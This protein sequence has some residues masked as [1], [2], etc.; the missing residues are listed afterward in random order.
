MGGASNFT[1][2]GWDGG[3]GLSRLRAGVAGLVA[4][5]TTTP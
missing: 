2:E 1:P 4:G 3:E 5:V